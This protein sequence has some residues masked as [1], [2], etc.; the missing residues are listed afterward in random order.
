MIE[1][2]KIHTEDCQERTKGS[3]KA[4]DDPKYYK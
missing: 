2:T 1:L 3:R 4:Y